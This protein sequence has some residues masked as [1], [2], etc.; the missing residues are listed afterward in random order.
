MV[1][2]DLHLPRPPMDYSLASHGLLFNSN[3][4]FSQNLP[5]YFVISTFHGFLWASPLLPMVYCLIAI[6]FIT[7]NLPYPPPMAYNVSTPIDPIA[8]CHSI[9]DSFDYGFL[10]LN[11][12]PMTSLIICTLNCFYAMSLPSPPPMTSFCFQKPFLFT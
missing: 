4:L 1:F 10:L 6:I 11:P 5:W 7:P 2:C 12:P 9:F 3:N 8:Q